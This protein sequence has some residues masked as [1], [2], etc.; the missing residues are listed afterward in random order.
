MQ[1]EALELEQKLQQELD[2][3]LSALSSDQLS[4]LSAVL[5]PET[6][7][8]KVN[9]CGRM[10][11]LKPLTVKWIR[12]VHAASKP[13]AEKAL[14]ANQEQKVFDIDEPLAECLFTVTGILADAYGWDD[15][16]TKVAEEDILLEEMQD[17]INR[18]QELNNTSDFLLSPLRVLLTVMKAAEV[19]T[20]ID[21][22]RFQKKL[23]TGVLPQNDSTVLS[24]T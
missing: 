5:F 9:L 22:G 7:T 3:S 11:I 8:D 14:K 17:V 16:K 1:N 21:S 19:A 18:Q 15:V 10:R 4:K 24:T 6:H 13:L 23:S 20:V 12:K 2:L